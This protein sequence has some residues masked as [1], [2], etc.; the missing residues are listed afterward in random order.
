MHKLVSTNKNDTDWKYTVSSLPIS[1]LIGQ[2]SAFT[3]NFIE[4]V[5]CY[6]RH[7]TFYGKMKLS[8]EWFRFFFFVIL[9]SFVRPLMSH[10][11]ICLLFIMLRI[12]FFAPFFYLPRSFFHS[13]F[14]TFCFVFSIQEF[15]LNFRLLF[16]FLFIWLIQ[17]V[18]CYFQFR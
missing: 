18:N 3:F 12:F 17:T 1:L 11:K 10:S 7:T 6:E 15:F 4:I 8:A 13:S 9:N 5:I 14:V 16:I 2:G